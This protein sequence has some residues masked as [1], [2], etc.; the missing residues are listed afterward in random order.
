MPVMDGSETLD[1]MNENY[2]HIPV[3]MLTLYDEDILIEDYL[4]RGAKAFVSKSTDF[5]I[6]IE[7]IKSIVDP[8]FN[9]KLNTCSVGDFTPR[10]KE[11]IPHLCD[12]KTTEQIASHFNV[13]PKTIEGHRARL[14]AKTGCKSVQEFLRF[15]LDRGLQFLKKKHD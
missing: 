10:E 1:Y 11:I 3:V 13:A 2:P 5:D 9:V 6:M 7:T 8:S 15:A 12:G 4:L 14:F